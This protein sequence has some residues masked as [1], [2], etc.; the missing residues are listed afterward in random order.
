MEASTAQLMVGT[1]VFL[2]L[3][4]MSQED[5]QSANRE[6]SLFKVLATVSRSVFLGIGR[7]SVESSANKSRFDST[8]EKM[9]LI[10]IKKSVG[11]RTLPWGRPA[12]VLR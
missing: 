2:A 1:F 12:L 7:C 11:P 8:W 6:R 9:S 5:A 4:L 10:K 3:K